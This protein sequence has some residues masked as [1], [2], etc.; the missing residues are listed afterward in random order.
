MDLSNMENIVKMVTDYSVLYGIRMLGAIAILIV[1]RVAAGWVRKGI[2]KACKRAG[3]DV[4]LTGFLGRLGFIFIQVFAVLAALAKFG[5][6]TT[7]FVAVLGA[8]GFAI[9]FAMQGSLSNFASGIMILV[10]RPFSVDDF[11]DAGGTA[12]TVKDIGLFATTLATPDN[13]MIIVPNSAVFGSTIKNYA[14]YDT[15]RVEVQV[16][17]SYGADIQKAMDVA[18]DLIKKDQRILADPAYQVA[19]MELADSSV[20]LVVRV[21]VE[22]AD[23]WNVKFDLTRHIKEAYDANNIEIPFPQ[24]VVHMVSST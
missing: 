10:F 22:R 21:W 5:I 18:A 9:G 24:R 3:V 11:I 1:G 20:N 17:I 15:R 4:A 14:G 16:G 19:V 23:F 2:A 13:I 7:S 6:Q 12:G 8:A